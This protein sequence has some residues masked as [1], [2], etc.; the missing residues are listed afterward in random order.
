MN[1]TLFT[2]FTLTIAILFGLVSGQPVFGLDQWKTKTLTIALVPEKNES[3]QLRRYRHI[4]R[5]LAD[6]LDFHVR[7]DLVPYDQITEN[8]ATG[9]AQAGFFGSLGYVIA[10]KKIGLI[11]L[12]RPV[13]Q[14]GTSTYAGY[15][16]V[17]KDGGIRSAA[18]MEKKKLVYVSKTTTAGYVFPKAYLLENGVSDIELYFSKVLYSGNHESSAWAVYTGEADVGAV[19]NHIFNDLKNYDPGFAKQ[20]MVLAESKSVPSN[21]FAVSPKLET[22]LREKIQELLLN[23]HLDKMGREKL[24]LF[25]A[26]KFIA[27]SDDD[28]Q[29]CYEMLINAEI[30]LSAQ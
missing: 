6:K 12:A 18:D 26:E 19:K 9:K 7:L 27:T 25:G 16:V 13:W 8:L 29:P 10:H 4:S 1:K 24:T 23:M 5:Y 30:D 21:G 11:P 2:T 20:M 15:L 14:D 3:D 22:E 17:R 28:Y